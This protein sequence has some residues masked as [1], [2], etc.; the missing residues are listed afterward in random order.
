MV[1]RCSD[2]LT[3]VIPVRKIPA[4][5]LII[6]NQVHKEDHIPGTIWEQFNGNLHNKQCQ[7][8][9]LIP[10]NSLLATYVNPSCSALCFL[11]I[12]LPEDFLWVPK[13]SCKFGKPEVPENFTHIP[14]TY[15]TF[16]E[17]KS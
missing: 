8:S 9:T 7:C 4:K 2:Y 13:W 10:S 11:S 15:T 3:I 12:G 17:A 16:P 1:E 14:N 6:N 5:L